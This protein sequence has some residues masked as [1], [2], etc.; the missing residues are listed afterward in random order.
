VIGARRPTGS[1]A[2]RAFFTAFSVTD[3]MRAG[4]GLRVDLALSDWT[5]V[6]YVEEGAIADLKNCADLVAKMAKT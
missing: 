4:R 3:P 2:A 6:V 5:G 1:G